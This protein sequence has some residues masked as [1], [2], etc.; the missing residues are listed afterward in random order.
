MQ[1]QQFEAKKQRTRAYEEQKLQAQRDK[2]KVARKQ[3]EKNDRINTIIAQEKEQK[4]QD[5]DMKRH[6]RGTKK[7]SNTPYLS[8]AQREIKEK[9]EFQQQQQDKYISGLNILESETM[10]K[11]YE[12]LKSNQNQMALF[13]HIGAIIQRD[14]PECSNNAL[15]EQESR[16]AHAISNYMRMPSKRRV[17][18]RNSL[19]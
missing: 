4:R 13:K 14:S 1:Q 15:T 17:Q 9:K 3:A 2:D 12:F 6:E 8:D 18:I 19:R 11:I 5:R 10:F 7:K 16:L